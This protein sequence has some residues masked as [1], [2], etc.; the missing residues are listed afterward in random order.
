MNFCRNFTRFN[1]L[2]DTE[3]NLCHKSQGGASAS[4]CILLAAPLKVGIITKSEKYTDNERKNGRK[5]EKSAQKL[6][7][8]ITTE[9][10]L[11]IEIPFA[12]LH[13]KW[14]A[15]KL[16][17]MKIVNKLRFHFLPSP[18]REIYTR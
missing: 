14:P 9:N 3:G 5:E 18:C 10:K 11:L 8:Y 17:T 2:L 13:N 12:I 4:T 15:A 7:S 6:Q 16:F 1:K